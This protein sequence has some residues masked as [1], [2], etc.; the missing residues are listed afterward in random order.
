MKIVHSADLHLDSP[1]RGLARYEGAPVDRIRGATREAFRRLVQ[2]CLDEEAA[3]LLIAGD[4]FDGDWRD[5][6]TGLFLAGELQRLRD[7]GTQVVVLHGNHD[8]ASPITRDLELPNHCH[9]LSST[10]P[11]TIDLGDVIVHGQSFATREVT[12]DL[13]ANY[14]PAVA[15]RFNVGLLHT[16]LSGRP[17]HSS[18]APT[19]LETLLDRGYQF[20][21]L[22]HV[23][24]R[25]VV[26]SDPLVLFPGNLQGRHIRESGAKGATVLTISDDHIERF[27][28][29]PLDVVRWAQVEVDLTACDGTD[30][31]LE[32]VRSALEATL[33]VAEQRLVAARLE[34]VGATRA[35]PRLAADP[36]T[37]EANL[38][39]LSLELGDLWIEKIKL[40]T[41]PPIDR[42]ALRA[43]NDAVGQLLRSLDDFAEDPA[44]LASVTA[45]LEELGKRLP[46]EAKT[47]D[48]AVSL[49]DPVYLREA[50][51]DV[52]AL[53]LPM[54]VGGDEG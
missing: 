12:E 29:R 11:E 8:A 6:A 27:E 28:H 34:L 50:L 20:W 25:E 49:T 39:L 7:V 13:A 2:L 14:P 17:G 16:A 23:H 51:G 3:L 10:T 40:R 18:Y 41:Q 43:R 4:L 38:R 46:K 19:R 53:L 44:Q 33:G 31:A 5:Y 22:G 37:F 9:V 21:G 36:D 26:H 1:L 15:G 54:L 45:E 47:G 32:A 30:D 24:A 35:H 42:A 52:E 48:D